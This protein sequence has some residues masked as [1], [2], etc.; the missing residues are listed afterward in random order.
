MDITFSHGESSVKG[1]EGSRGRCFPNFENIINKGQVRKSQERKEMSLKEDKDT[2]D[3]DNEN[4]SPGRDS[5]YGRK[6]K[7][8]LL[9]NQVM[10]ENFFQS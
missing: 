3:K 7:V 9:Q 1:H 8:V 5:S 6:L 4:S 2:L 10:A